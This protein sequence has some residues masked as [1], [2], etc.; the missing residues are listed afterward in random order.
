[1]SFKTKKEAEQYMGVF[2][3]GQTVLMCRGVEK[4]IKKEYGCLIQTYVKPGSIM[5]AEWK[6]KSADGILLDSCLP[7]NE[8]TRHLEGH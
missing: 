8:S 1:M 4:W 7:Y 3:P 6:H 5:F 2:E